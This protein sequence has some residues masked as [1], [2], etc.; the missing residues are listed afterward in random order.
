MSAC[1]QPDFKWSEWHAE[2]TYM[3]IQLFSD[4]NLA[5]NKQAWQSSNYWTEYGGAGSAVDGNASPD[6]WSQSCTRTKKEAQPWWTVDLG[7]VHGI[8]EVE[9]TNRGDCCGKKFIREIA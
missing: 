5:Q 2:N 7:Y 9:I 4:S 8:V 6:Y 3:S 1:V